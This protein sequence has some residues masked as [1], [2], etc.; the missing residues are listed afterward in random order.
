MTPLH[1]K[2]AEYGYTLS[3]SISRWQDVAHLFERKRMWNDHLGDDSWQWSTDSPAEVEKILGI[4]ENLWVSTVVEREAVAKKAAYKTVA[5]KAA[6]AYNLENAIK[7]DLEALINK[8]GD[9]VQ[10]DRSRL[11]SHSYS[12]RAVVDETTYHQVHEYMHH[13]AGGGVERIGVVVQRKRL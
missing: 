3:K 2:I 11:E 8:Y 12:T 7:I 4:P 10:E 13:L 5:K 6:S 9:E 1:L